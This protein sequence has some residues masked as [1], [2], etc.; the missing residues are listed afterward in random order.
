MAAIEAS[1]LDDRASAVKTLTAFVAKYPDDP[2][3]V[4]AKDLLDM[5]KGP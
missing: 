4:E 1:A 2:A 5:L 3:V